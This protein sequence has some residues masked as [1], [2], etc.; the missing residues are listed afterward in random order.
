MYA[1]FR[2]SD[3]SGTYRMQVSLVS[4]VVSVCDAGRAGASVFGARCSQL[5]D[6]GDGAD[7]RTPLYR[8]SAGPF[9][10]GHFAAYI[11]TPSELMLYFNHH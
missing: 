10:R 2:D 4:V 3:Y 8:S 5:T 9:T 1:P 6:R 7:L 11:T